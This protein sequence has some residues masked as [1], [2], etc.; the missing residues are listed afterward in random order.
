MEGPE[1]HGPQGVSDEPRLPAEGL[2]AER[3]GREDGEG[4]EEACA[5]EEREEDALPGGAE[6]RRDHV[7]D[8]EGEPGKEGRPGI[9]IPQRIVEHRVQ[10]QV[11]SALERI[12]EGGIPVV[13]V[14]PAGI[15]GRVDAVAIDMRELEGQAVDEVDAQKQ[16]ES[17]VDDQDWGGPTDR[18]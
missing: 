1:A 13:R 3:V 10:A 9:L 5:Q 8:Q 7:S 12:T 6:E 11:A 17:E 16:R 14:R 2:L 4:A 15:G 18:E